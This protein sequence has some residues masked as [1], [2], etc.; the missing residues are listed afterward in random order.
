MCIHVR[1]IV[2]SIVM[3]KKFST[4]G[5]NLNEWL[6]LVFP[7]HFVSLMEHTR[8]QSLVDADPSSIPLISHFS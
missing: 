5:V 7:H 2:S 1:V 8:R 3:V 6:R 4:I